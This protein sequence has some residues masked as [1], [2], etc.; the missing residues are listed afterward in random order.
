MV[1]RPSPNAAVCIDDLS[2]DA[3]MAADH[4]N[5]KA[6]ELIDVATQVTRTVP[7]PAEVQDFG[8]V[9][10]ARFSPDGKQL[11][12]ALARRNPDNEQGWVALAEVAGG[13][14]PADRDQPG[15]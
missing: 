14:V 3:S 7:P 1:P 15:E 2:P 6:M 8:V 13:P 9:G 12:F 4:C 11:A 10:G 5:P